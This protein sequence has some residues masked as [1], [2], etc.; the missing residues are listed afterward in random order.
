MNRRFI[1]R[2]LIT[3]LLISLA[4]SLGQTATSY[5]AELLVPTPDNGPY[6]STH[7]T[8][9]LR[10]Y[11]WSVGATFDIAHRS[12]ELAGPSGGRVSGV[13]EDFLLAH[14]LGA[15]SVLDWLQLGIDVP[16]ALVDRTV[17]TTT[18]NTSVHIR[19]SDIRLEAKF[20]LIDPDRYGWGIAAIPFVSLPTGSSARLIGNG[21]VA[22]GAKLAFE[23]PDI[24]RVIRIAL[25]VGYE[26]RDSTILFGTEIDDW[27]LYSVAANFRVTE[28]FEII[29][30]IYGRAIAGE[31]FN[32]ESQ[33][34]LEMAGIFRIFFMK[35]RLS[36]DIGGSAGL[37]S[38]VGAPVWR[39]IVRLAFKPL[40]R[41]AHDDVTIPTPSELTPEDY[42]LLSKS[43]PQ[44][45][46]DWD[47]QTDDEACNKVYELRGLY[48]ECP[49]PEDFD[50]SMYDEACEKV[51]ELQ[52]FDRDGDGVPDY[53]DRCPDEP[54]PIEYDGCPA[55]DVVLDWSEGRIKSDKILFEFN[56]AKLGDRAH[57]VL[58]QIA[59]ALLPKIK[60][61]YIRKVFIEGHT[62][63]IGLREYNQDLSA[64]RARAVRDFLQSKGI[65]A[66][67][68][69]AVGYGQ[70]RPAV[71]NN[72]E[73]GQRQNRRVE[74]RF[75]AVY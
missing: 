61:N 12:L 59:G 2:L 31:L 50:A 27:F 4:P 36:L 49:P 62:D 63:S 3:A 67:K 32:S 22:G 8:R 54:G 37:L 44:N 15:F 70:M 57:K 42:Y 35:R 41:S 16:I 72:T 64:R 45:P 5:N 52:G 71:S 26:M 25:N 13:L 7:S 33:S 43:C 73:Q 17:D 24:G 34:P 6:L 68:M 14:L 58:S 74:I 47:A 38:G 40:A 19:F 1:V 30:E 56:S 29:P 21:S 60:M 75:D 39:G 11:G 9:T 48:G 65:P 20:K 10:K 66:N 18:G 46:E 69:S 28:Y 55:G 51:Y 23:S 53:L